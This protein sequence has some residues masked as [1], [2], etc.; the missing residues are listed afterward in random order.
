[1]IGKEILGYRVEEEI[2]SGGFGTVYR[3]VKSNAA[4]TY[5]RALK[6][7][8]LPTK[9][10]YAGVLN[11]MGGDY[12]K[13]DDYFAGILADIVGEIRILSELSES[14]IQ[15]IVRYYENDIIET[16]SPRSYD[17]YIMMEYLTP[18]PD[19]FTGR[20]FTVRDV[21]RLGKDILAA[22]ISCHEKNIIHRDIKDDNIFVSAEGVYKLGDFGVS[23]ALKDRSRAESVKGTPN[24]IAPEV[25][26][27]KE[28]YDHTVDIYSLG[29]LL[30]KLL[31]KSRNPF[32]PSFPAPYSSL[33]E[34]AAFEARMAGKIPELPMDAQNDLGK[35]IVKALMPR[36]KRYDS[37][38]EFLGA[39]RAAEQGLG[40]EAL[41]LV[42]NTP[43]PALQSTPTPTPS[44][45]GATVD[46]TAGTADC[47]ESRN[48]HMD[49]TV[50]DSVPGSET[51]LE[52]QLTADKNL[53]KTF[54]EETTPGKAFDSP[55]PPPPVPDPDPDPIPEPAPKK[56]KTAFSDDTLSRD[57]SSGAGAWGYDSPSYG[58]SWDSGP[59][60]VEAI[61]KKDLSWLIYLAPVLIALIYITVYVILI[62]VFYGKGVSFIEWL[63]SRP[64]DILET[65]RT[66]DWILKPA[67]VIIGLKIF[68]WVISVAF[69][70]SLFFV[71][72]TIQNRRPAVS[73]DAK[74]TG[75]EAYLLA[76]EIYEAAKLIDVKEA[77]PAK[78][79]IR[80][81]YERLRNES[82]FGS[83]SAMVIT[84]ENEIASALQAI[85]STVPGLNNPDA[86]PGCSQKILELCQKTQSALNRRIELKKR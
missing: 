59:P 32:L 17:I 67:A 6:H 9:K 68:N 30:Y 3:V 62:P 81:V 53:F 49:E 5:T 65:L 11:S 72:H 38:K 85:R 29:V 44:P 45:A 31:N 12:A 23:K 51:D 20:S 33:D 73:V 21:I 15:N 80:G 82:A 69:C 86:L 13:A 10:Q 52:P 41:S 40:A 78:L 19:Y 84:C 39:L 1:M 47:G 7:I 76:M 56:K 37:A 50:G 25:Y 36:A 60:Q 22:L 71:G 48:R 70:I 83:G 2:G 18:L 27:G 66:P 77:N 26:L 43:I 46:Y 54:A 58:G 28:S 57:G 64:D 75:K 4:G 79:A 8:V 14:G 24:F 61:T 34:D 42:L 63:F 74:L 16:P 55:P 35:A